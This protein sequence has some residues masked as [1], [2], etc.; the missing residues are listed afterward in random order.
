MLRI[1][2]TFYGYSYT[3]SCY[4]RPGDCTQVEHKPYP[5]TG[6]NS[7]T[8]DLPGGQWGKKISNCDKDSNYFQVE[9]SCEPG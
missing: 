7:C 8:I 1:K 4:F 3:N 5:C 9:Y 2:H 6:R